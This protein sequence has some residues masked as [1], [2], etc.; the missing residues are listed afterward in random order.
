MLTTSTIDRQKS[1]LQRR[2]DLNPNNPNINV[3]AP[4]RTDILT[5]GQ[6]SAF[7]E[8]F[9]L[10]D[11]NGGGSIDADEL[12]E[13]LRSA[14]I[15]VTKDE[16]N[17]VLSSMDKDGNGEI[18]F[19]EFLQ[20][21]TNT[22]R[23][24][25]SV[26]CKEQEAEA[27]QQREVLLFEA[28][29]QFMRKSAL[30]SINEIVGYYHQKYKKV[31]TPHVIR[32][33]AAGARLIGLSE[34]QIRRHLE[35]L[36]RSSMSNNKSPYAQPPYAFMH[37][38]RQKEVPRPV[39]LEKITEITEESSP[40]KIRENLK[41][42]V[43]DAPRQSTCKGRI[44]LKIV[45]DQ[46]EKDEKAG[47]LP[48]LIPTKPHETATS[49]SLR[50]KR[51]HNGWVAQRFNPANIRDHLPILTTNSVKRELKADGGVLIDP[52]KPH[53]LDFDDAPGLRFKVTGLTNQYYKG[54]QNQKSREAETHWHSLGVNRM[55]S[56]HLRESYRRVFKAYVDYRN[57]PVS[58]LCSSSIA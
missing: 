9:D 40:T 1:F 11:S 58:S 8:V 21:M 51:R 6:K 31:Q 49:Q 26:I 46:K 44:R 16:I 29:T 55:P 10:F 20:L 36:R 52:D 35:Q 22:E 17:E 27:T 54:I 48:S 25:E 24:L 19:E 23:F 53:S 38:C 57:T 30:H 41:I 45:W 15:Q 7:R 13:A 4:D 3:M 33:Y 42:L 18:D 14:D 28:L 39:K 50:K 34:Q 2:R 37:L 47:K 32:H 12:D 43:P 5:Q 56:Q